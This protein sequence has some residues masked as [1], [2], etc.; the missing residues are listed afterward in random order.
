VQPWTALRPLVTAA[1]ALA[2]LAPPA[3][4][5]A[6]REQF[7]PA[8]FDWTGPYAARAS[9]I[10]AGMLDYLRLLNERDGGVHGV[11]FV[12]QKCDTEYTSARGLEC[13]ER[14]KGRSPTLIHPV[15]T[16]V[17]YSIIERASADRIP[18][19]SIGYGRPDAADGRLFPY[20]FPLVTTAWSEAAAIVRYIGERSGGMAA[21]RGKRIALLYHDSADGKEPIPVLSELAARYG[22]E[23]TTLAVAPPGDDQHAQWQR[24]TGL[25]PEWVVLSGLGAMNAAALRGAA[26]FGFP[27]NRMVGVWWS[28]AEEDVAPA[29]NAAQGFVAAGFSVPG[30]SFPVV[31]EIR[32][33]VYGDGAGEL[34]ETSHIGS[35]YYN[36]GVVYGIV[37]A[38]A[39]RIA[40]EQYGLGKPVT[41]EQVRWALERLRLDPA[42]LE[43]LGALG[44]MPALETSCADHEGAGVVR[45]TRWDG[46]RWTAFTDWT[47]PLPEDRAA[48]RRLIVESANAYAKGKGIKPRSCPQ[49]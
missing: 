40:Q 14:A 39:V 38:E 24:I 22:Y 37:T 47:A 34:A 12:W 33:F 41:G 19:V 23:L 25:R 35:V 15:S 1:A 36:R 3:R 49:G 6:P 20:V 18:V 5:D 17:A 21:L 9:G 45:F 2:L 16:G 7:I 13:Y 48:V 11:K 30:Q 29:G 32:R 28:G 26:R 31:R 42:R 46:K 43:A 27:R 10:A 4:A 8:N 44:M